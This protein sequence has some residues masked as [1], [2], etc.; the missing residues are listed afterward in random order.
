MR[1]VSIVL[2]ILMGF[3]GVTPETPKRAP[4]ET[5]GQHIWRS[6]IEQRFA[7]G[8]AI[9]LFQLINEGV[10]GLRQRKK[11][12][13]EDI[14]FQVNELHRQFFATIPPDE[15]LK[16]RVTLFKVKARHPI[17]RFTGLKRWGGK[18][19]KIVARSGESWLGSTTCYLVDD[20]NPDSNEALAGRVY[21]LNCFLAMELPEWDA[22]QSDCA[23]N[24]EYSKAGWLTLERAS[25]LKLKNPSLCGTVVRDKH[26]TKFGS[27]VIDGPKPNSLQV[28]E[29]KKALVNSFALMIGWSL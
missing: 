10:M 15:K 24:R 14:K 28:D 22:S 1:S 21:A 27:L 9:A 8:L 18:Q 23:K 3:L 11:G 25:C 13:K 7:V 17:L 5:I 2:A 12:T 4:D 20:E 26:N 16:Y 19:L 29:A 6:G